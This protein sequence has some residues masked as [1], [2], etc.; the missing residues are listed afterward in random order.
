MEEEA[1]L[2]ERAGCAGRRVAGAGQGVAGCA[3]DPGVFGVHGEGGPCGTAGAASLPPSLR[4]ADV[5]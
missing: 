2:C 5:S 3:G 1:W 4:E